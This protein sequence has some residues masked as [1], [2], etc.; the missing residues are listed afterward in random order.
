[1]KAAVVATLAFT[2]AV[3]LAV[4]AAYEGPRT[5]KASEVLKPAQVK[6]PHYEVAPDVPTDGYLHVF[7]LKTDYGSLE[8]EGKNILLL[9]EY[10]TG[11]LAQLDEVSK[12][13][14]FVK[15]AGDSLVKTGKGVAM[16]V[17]D[18]GATAKNMGSGLKRFGSN[19]GRS[20]K[21]TTDKAVDSVSGDDKDKKEGEKKDDKS[22]TDKAAE[23]SEGIA[24]SVFGVNGAARRWAQK[25]GVDPYTTNPV[26][27]KSL[28]EFGRIDAAG[29]LA[30]KIAVPI[31]PIVGTTATVG[32]LVW[33]QDPQALMKR[34][35]QL[36]K[37]GGA[38][39]DGLKKL[40]L[41]K[42]F[43]LTLMTRLAN[44][45]GAI[46]AKGGGDYVETAAEADTYREAA[47]FVHS[48]EMAAQVHQKTPV[49]AVLT[50]SRALVAK[51]ANGRAVVVLPVDWIRWTEAFDK[52][53]AEVTSRAKAELG[54]TTLELRTTAKLSAAAK[55]Q[56]TGRGWTIVE[57]LPTAFEV[58][59]AGAAASA[60]PAAAGAPAAKPAP[61]K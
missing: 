59:K 11:A 44:A 3:S 21:R 47:F 24:N 38:T 55:A 45:L 14:V 43:T 22:T 54:A 53:S 4:A 17:S 36:L 12:T 30:V 20:A 8:A 27:R 29:G 35:E 25:V 6:G 49:A 46:K 32:N 2:A 19:L 51:L 33:G 23:A 61:K 52:A 13:G 56:L 58:T 57:G 15:A 18:P 28:I 7:Q 42:G 41:S 50:D 16:A 40:Y 10:E 60:K 34:N 1:M 26:L 31:P 48:A 5:F 37:D 9:R 39:A